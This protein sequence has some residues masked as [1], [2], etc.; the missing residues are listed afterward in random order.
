MGE[1]SELK[2]SPTKS[3][4]SFQSKGSFMLSNLTLPPELP[5]DDKVAPNTPEI[6]TSNLK[7][8]PS[9]AN[10]KGGLLSKKLFKKV[11]SEDDFGDSKSME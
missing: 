7:K 11:D 6:K 9:K 4:I 2:T 3:P 8:P 1:Q 10:T 5:N